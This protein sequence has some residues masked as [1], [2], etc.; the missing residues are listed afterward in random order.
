VEF[1]LRL[2]LRTSNLG[3]LRVLVMNLN[4]E[5]RGGRKRPRNDGSS[6][7][8]T[9]MQVPNLTFIHRRKDTARKSSYDPLTDINTRLTNHHRQVVAAT[10]RTNMPPPRSRVLQAS[11]PGSNDAVRERLSRESSERERAAELIRRRRRE[12]EGSMTP[13]TV[14]GGV[15]EGYSDR[16]NSRE[17]EDAQRR[18]KDRHW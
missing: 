8:L 6:W 1:H 17:T 3:T 2:M 13:S 16:Y 11:R 15:D 9:Q 12:M 5:I 7:C 10:S 4:H 14:H 18:R